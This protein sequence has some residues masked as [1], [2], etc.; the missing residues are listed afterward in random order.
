MNARQ[1]HAVLAAGVENP[2]LISTWRTEPTRLLRLGIEPGCLDLDAL[3]K[4]A[5]LTIKVR[6]NGVR[7]Q[8]PGTFRL[9]A[10][11]GLE[12]GLFADYAAFRVSS[13]RMYA[14]TT[15]QRAHDLVQFMVHWIDPSVGIHAL[16]G[17][18]VRHEQALLLLNATPAPEAVSG[19]ADDSAAGVGL[20]PSA[21]PQ[22]C[23]RIVLHEMQSDP[24][25][26]AAALR[27]TV[28]PLAHIP[29]QTRYYCYWRR[30]Q[31]SEID[32]LEVDEFG[33][34]VLSLVDG[35]RSVA[36]ISRRLGGSRRPTRGFT[37]SLAQLEALGILAFGHA[38][39]ADA[40]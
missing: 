40:A 23:G 3:W 5:G 24:F 9:M 6:H 26:L 18:I 10:V 30:H 8:L 32:V 4:F 19:T 11:A 35:S 13:G 1:V 17:D 31:A 21:V 16:L 33:Y 2:A 7:Q 22:I 36:D 38:R 20:R 14:A 12:I 27:Q 15:S 25:L 29:L 28:P 39:T 34:Y 37:Q